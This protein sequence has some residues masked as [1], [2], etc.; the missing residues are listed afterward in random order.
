M[1]GTVPELMFG[2]TMK[3]NFKKLKTT[4]LSSNIQYI[5]LVFRDKVSL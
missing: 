4:N 1:Q 3:F 2:Y 5:Y